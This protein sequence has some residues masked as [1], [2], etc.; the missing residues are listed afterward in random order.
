MSW[1]Y[2][3][4]ADATPL[5]W[6]NGGGTTR[7]LLAWPPGVADWHWRMSVA[8]VDADGPFSV[9]A[10]VQRWF[11]VLDGAGVELALGQGGNLQTQ[12]LTQRSEAFGFDG[13][14]PVDCTLIE[15]PTQ[16]FNLMVRSAYARAHM[17]R[18]RSTLAVTAQDGVVCALW[19]GASGARL[20][21]ANGLWS[22]PAQTLA[23][24]SEAPAQGLHI[25]SADAI[26]MEIRPWQ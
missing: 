10:G 19:A 9:F 3:A 18:V 7:E 24:I 11:A 21:D 20:R 4:L 26:F 8:Q 23:W 5:P 12:R 17:Q 15:G 6:K 1:Q 22:V 14:L 13:A 25:D 2:I 16:D